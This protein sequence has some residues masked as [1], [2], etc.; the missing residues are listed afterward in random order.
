VTLHE[1]DSAH[2]HGTTTYR[3]TQT[4]N[5]L[6]SERVATSDSSNQALLHS[7]ASALPHICTGSGPATI[8]LYHSLPQT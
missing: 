6:G 8:L 2:M 3:F 5:P 4:L 7:L 1:Q